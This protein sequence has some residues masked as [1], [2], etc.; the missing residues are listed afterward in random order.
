VPRLSYT[1]AAAGLLAD[2]RADELSQ[3]V[4]DHLRG[5]QAALRHSLGLAGVARNSVLALDQLEPALQA[6]LRRELGEEEFTD[7]AGEGPIGSLDGDLRARLASAMGSVFLMEAYR[8]LILAVGD[9][10]WIDYL[11]QME[12][13]R[14]SIGLEA[15]GQRDPLVQY[16]SRAFDMFQQLTSEI[17]SGVVS[18]LFR[19]QAAARPPQAV[20]A[21]EAAPP[22]RIP[23]AVATRSGGNGSDGGR[24]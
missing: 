9:R 14:T 21:T 22:A 1:F 2:W 18:N 23:E 24:R 15:Y 3:R 19:T 6:A 20:P 10:L 11:T 16:K 8:G 5:A 12:A 7:L 4:L 17:R 13:L